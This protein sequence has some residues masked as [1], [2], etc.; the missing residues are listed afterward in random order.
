MQRRNEVQHA[1]VLSNCEISGLVE[2]DEGWTMEKYVTTF[3]M[4]L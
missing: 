2:T 4:L 1:Q 3:N